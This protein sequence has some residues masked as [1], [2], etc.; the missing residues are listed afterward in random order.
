LTW[1]TPG[2]QSITVTAMNN[3]GTV[4]DTHMITVAKDIYLPIVLRNAGP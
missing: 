4:T 3:G 1:T 2:P